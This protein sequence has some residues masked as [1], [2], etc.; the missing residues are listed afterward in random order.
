MVKPHDD[1]AYR[2]KQAVNYERRD[3]REAQTRHE[4]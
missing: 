1:C 2:P 3:E 4:D